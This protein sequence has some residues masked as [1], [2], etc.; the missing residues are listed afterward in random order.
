MAAQ[1]G[2][3]VLETATSPG[4][5]GFTL[6]GAEANRRAFSTAFPNGGNVLYFADDGS[7]AE[8]GIGTLTVGTP[9]TLARSTVLGNTAGTKV[10][11]NFPGSVEVYNEIPAEMVAVL[12]QDGSLELAGS[13]TVKGKT[14]VQNVDDF[15]SQE[16]VPAVQADSRY[17]RLA[18]GLANTDTAV[19][20]LWVDLTT[21][22]GFPRIGFAGANGTTYGAYGVAKVNA[23]IGACIQ[24]ANPGIANAQAGT[25]LC[26][27]PADGLPYLAYNG[28]TQIVALALD[29]A[30]VNKTDG[31][32]SALTVS[33][34][35]GYFQMT[36]ADAP[37]YATWY[38]PTGTATD[39]VLDI[40]S[41][42]GDTKANVLRITADGGINILGSGTFQKSG[43]N[44][45]FKSDLPSLPGGT[46]LTWTVDNV[47]TE[48]TLDLPQTFKNTP[49]VWCQDVSAV[50]VHYA[51]IRNITTTNFQV[52]TGSNVTI[53][54]L[55][56]FAVGD[57]A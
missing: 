32:M 9:S 45:A 11:L 54:T 41:N 1:L 46:L 19:N 35:T 39:G 57:L 3:Y 47:A 25:S 56:F 42:V 18:T 33:I 26:V 43:S 48:T 29:S 31:A 40:Y 5:G 36:N 21:E 55:R 24:N 28:N 15:S 27:N 30:K 38:R 20:A 13:L 14:L 4:T 8:W 53:P 17:L 44:V 49:A 52:Q 34:G 6:N 50:N 23:L 7:Q 10:A 12:E 22:N 2:N 37:G 16:A 51:C